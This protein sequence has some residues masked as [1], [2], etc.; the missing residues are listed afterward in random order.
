MQ[1]QSSRG[2]G[3][4]PSCSFYLHIAS[5]QLAAVNHLAKQSVHCSL[6]EQRVIEQTL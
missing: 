4:A 5:V 6:T 2:Q 1:I 3:P